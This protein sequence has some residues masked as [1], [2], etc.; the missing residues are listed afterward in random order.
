MEN[1]TGKRARARPDRHRIIDDTPQNLSANTDDD[2]IPNS[3]EWPKEMG[4]EATQLRARGR[5]A[6][7]NATG[8]YETYGRLPFDDGWSDFSEDIQPIR[9]ETIR[10]SAKKAITYNSSPDLPFDRTINPYKGC[11][12]GCIYCYARPNHTYAGLSA[13]ID[14]ESKIFIKPGIAK[15]LEA[16]IA[17]PR[18]RPKT[19][20]LGGDTDIYQPVERDLKITRE[21][22]RVASEARHPIAFVTKSALVL[23]DLD[24]LAP[25]AEQGLVRACISLTSLDNKLSRKMEPRAAAPHRRLDVIRQLA[26]AG[27]PVTVMT[28][29]IIPAINDMEIENLLEAAVNAGADNAGYVLLR[30][31]NEI[32]YL[33]EEWLQVNYPDRADKVM[34]ILRSMRGSKTYQSDFGLRQRGTGPYAKLIAQRFKLAIERLN[35]R[36]TKSEL[37][38]DLFRPPRPDGYRQMNLF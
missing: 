13:G 26:Q 36:N 6:V 18:Y 35:I 30:L 12:H 27:I 9:T 14:F 21:I 11:E 17:K 8:R 15:L 20:I 10:E 28:A 4:W 23:R 1:S 38:T 32:A 16:E 2:D 29:P 34:N 7:S 31:P 24:I 5:G 33:F 37:R 25:M 22:L 19:L 3:L